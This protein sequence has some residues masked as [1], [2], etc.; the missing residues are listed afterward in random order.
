MAARTVKSVIAALGRADLSIEDRALLTTA[1]L[2]K[3]VALPIRDIITVDEKKSIFVNGK[4]LDFEQAVQLRESAR[5]ALANHA[6]RLVRQQVLYAAVVAGVHKVE[7]PAQMFFSRA[8]IWFGK[9][10]EALLRMLAGE[11]SQDGEEIAL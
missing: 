2:D 4:P 9:E 3:L 1:V 5:G 8:A 6:M 10:E 7:S 11:D